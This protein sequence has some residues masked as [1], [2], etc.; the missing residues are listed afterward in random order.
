MRD[1]VGSFAVIRMF[2]KT[3][4]P[5]SSKAAG[6]QGTHLSEGACNQEPDPGLCYAAFTLYYFNRET[7]KCEEFVYGGCGGNA[8]RF[9]SLE[10]CQILCVRNEASAPDANPTMTKASTPGTPAVQAAESSRRPSQTVFA[11]PYHQLHLALH[12][13]P[14]EWGRFGLRPAVFHFGRPFL[15]R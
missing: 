3:W 8:N 13:R 5:V 6:Y 9:G 14:D 4:F 7:K 11:R 12:G 2:L 15:V 1:D 10:E